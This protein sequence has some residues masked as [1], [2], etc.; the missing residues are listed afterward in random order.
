MVT[1][2]Q[3]IVYVS[4]PRMMRSRIIQGTE[5]RFVR[6]KKNDLFGI[7]EMWIDKNEKVRVSDLERTSVRWFKTT[8]LLRRIF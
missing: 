6:C 5:F 7:T 8:C 4:S 3:L 1:Q 2:P